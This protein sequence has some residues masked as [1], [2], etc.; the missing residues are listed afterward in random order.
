MQTANQGFKTDMRAL[1]QRGAPESERWA[2]I[3][4]TEADY[5]KRLFA[6]TGLDEERLDDLLAG[7]LLLPGAPAATS[8][9][10]LPSEPPPEA[11]RDT[12]VAPDKPR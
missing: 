4:A 5:Q 8:T 1:V 6:I 9:S 3:R 7:N 11:P 10:E 12:V 2:L